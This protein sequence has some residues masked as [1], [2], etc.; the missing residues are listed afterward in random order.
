MRLHRCQCWNVAGILLA[1][2]LGACESEP[3]EPT[4]EAPPAAV[5]VAALAGSWTTRAD[6]PFD[7]FGAVSASVTNSSGRSTLYVIGGRPVLTAGAGRITDAVRAYDVSANTW[8]KVAPYPIRIQLANEA[9]EIDGKIYVSGG[10]TRRWN[11]ATE[12]Y[13]NQA[14]RSLYVYDPAANAWTRKRDMP[15]STIAGLAAASQGRLYL[16]GSCA[17]D[18]DCNGPVNGGLW[19]YNPATDRWALLGP[20]PHNP[21]GVGG[22]I[23]GKLYVLADAP[24]F[25]EFSQLDIYDPATGQWSS[26]PHLPFPGFCDLPATTFQAKVYLVGCPDGGRRTTLVFDP[27]VGAWTEAAPPPTERGLATLSRV[28][29]NGQARLELVGGARPGNNLQFTP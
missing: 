20:T 17:S 13:V 4:A 8:R 29:V 14:V 7:I 23:G 28:F 1:G 11:E 19:R 25:T 12:S 21:T 26:G 27:K 3:L 10:F 6:Y 24:S 18:I 16:A 22:F 2:A 9:V 5:T 15:T